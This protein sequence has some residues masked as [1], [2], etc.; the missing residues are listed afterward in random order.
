MFVQRPLSKVPNIE[1]RIVSPNLGSISS[2]T[3]LRPTRRVSKRLRFSNLKFIFQ[4][5]NRLKIYFRFKDHVPETLSAVA[6]RLHIPGKPAD[7]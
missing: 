6:A 5:S 2:I 7:I 3:K 1:L 4:A